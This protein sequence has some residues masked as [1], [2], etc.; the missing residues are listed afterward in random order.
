MTGCTLDLEKLRRSLQSLSRGD[1]LVI[2]QRAVELVPNARL[3]ALLGDRVQIDAPVDVATEMPSLLEE[4]RRFHATSM[5]G[6]YYE[7]FPV[8]GKNCKGSVIPVRPCMKCRT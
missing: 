5:S 6:T 7:A 3:P 4:V 8:N 1:L 2:A